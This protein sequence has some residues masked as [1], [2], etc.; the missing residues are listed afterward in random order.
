MGWK[1][2]QD[3]WPEQAGWQW[4]VRR[5]V[6][7]VLSLQGKGMAGAFACLMPCPAL[8]PLS[9]LSCSLSH[10]SLF[11]HL[12][13]SLSYVFYSTSCCSLS[14]SSLCAM[15]LP[16]ISPQ[17]HDLLICGC[18]VGMP[19]VWHGSSRHV[20]VVFTNVAFQPNAIQQKQTWHFPLP[21]CVTVMSCCV[22]YH[23]CDDM[24]MTAWLHGI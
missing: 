4:P 1:I 16:S 2:G 24:F 14:L 9:L 23:S 19:I 18:V 15:H 3:C 20:V 10:S 21:V 22:F 12:S 11:L 5:V 17:G 8:S 6:S 13:L 7:D